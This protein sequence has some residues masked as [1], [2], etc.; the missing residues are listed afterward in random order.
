MRDRFHLPRPPATHRCDADGERDLAQEEEPI[1]D[2]ER[3]ADDAEQADPKQPVNQTAGTT[4]PRRARR[5]SPDEADN[6]GHEEQKRPAPAVVDPVDREPGRLRGRRCTSISS[7]TAPITQSHGADD[8][9]SKRRLGSFR[10]ART[11]TGTRL[12]RRAPRRNERGDAKTST[13]G[14][15][16]A[17]ADEERLRADPSRR[18]HGR[19]SRQARDTRRANPL[20]RAIGVRIA[21]RSR[22]ARQTAGFGSCDDREQNPGEGV[23][24]HG[25]GCQCA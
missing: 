7:Q 11:Q 14:G 5:A 22:F 17:E 15:E 6:A 18:R 23:D 4:W 2:G 20:T 24:E 21:A 16:R 13:N 10:A 19:A 1:P 8:R 9:E 12:R 3:E 25:H